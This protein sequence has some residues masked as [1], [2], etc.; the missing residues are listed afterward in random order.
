MTF[1]D[2][3]MLAMTILDLRVADSPR[4][5][6]WILGQ[7][8]GAPDAEQVRRA[9]PGPPPF[10][11]SA[12]ARLLST[13]V[14]KSEARRLDAILRDP[15]AT[16]WIECH[17]DPERFSLRSEMSLQASEYAG[18]V[19]DAWEGTQRIDPDADAKSLLR[20]LLRE[21]DRRSALENLRERFFARW[22]QEPIGG[23]ALAELR[24]RHESMRLRRLDTLVEFMQD[25]TWIELRDGVVQL[26][27]EGTE[28]ALKL[29]E[30]WR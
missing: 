7:Q 9:L 14:G 8:G 5:M 16:K 13:S 18:A 15:R 3:L 25:R 2:E 27:D 4:S 28:E 22:P 21:P 19:L 20:Y 24:S 11:A 29:P 10:V 30:E 23:A 6:E 17:A 12:I 26:T 1:E